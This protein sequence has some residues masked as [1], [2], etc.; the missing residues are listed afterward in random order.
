VL[1]VDPIDK[2][3]STFN[4]EDLVVKMEQNPGQS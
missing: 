3:N 4:T 2:N 1:T